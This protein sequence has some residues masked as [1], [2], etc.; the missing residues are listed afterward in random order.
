[1]GMDPVKTYRYLR[2]GI[3]AMVLL[4]G[5]AVVHEWWQTG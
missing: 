3:I 4:A 5:A 2:L 1:M